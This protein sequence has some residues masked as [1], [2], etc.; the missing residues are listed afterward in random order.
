MR[1]RDLVD[2]MSIAPASTK[3]TLPIAEARTK[4][5]EILN[6]GSINGVSPVIENWHLVSNDQVEFTVIKLLKAD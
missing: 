1:P 2:K 4:A 6:Q 5:R 3:F